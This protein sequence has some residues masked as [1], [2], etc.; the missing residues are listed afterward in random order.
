MMFLQS[1]PKIMNSSSRNLFSML[2]SHSLFLFVPV[3]KMTIEQSRR[4]KIIELNKVRL[5]AGKAEHD[6]HVHYFCQALYR[7]FNWIK[8]SARTRSIGQ[9]ALKRVSDSGAARGNATKQC[10]VQSKPL[11]SVRYTQHY[12]IASLCYISS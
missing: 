7:P 8:D 1:L 3:Y 10:H 12:L 2:F 6:G 9:C 4:I 5:R 11:G